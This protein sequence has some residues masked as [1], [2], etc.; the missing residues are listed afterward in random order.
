[1]SC[2][3]SS[4]TWRPYGIWP[5]RKHVT[6]TDLRLEGALSVSWFSCASYHHPLK[7]ILGATEPLKL[8]V[9][10]RLVV[11]SQ[12]CLPARICYLWPQMIFTINYR[13]NGWGSFG[14]LL[15]SK[16]KKRIWEYCSSDLRQARVLNIWIPA[17]LLWGKWASGAWWEQRGGLPKSRAYLEELE[18]L[19]QSVNTLGQTAERMPGFMYQIQWRH[20]RGRL[21]K[22]PSHSLLLIQHPWQGL[23]PTGSQSSHCRKMEE[24]TGD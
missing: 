6:T 22:G 5:Q 18:L 20:F 2:E 24:L 23:A 17:K 3:F 7:L 11:L 8:R 4:V 16:E 15:F 14:E 19:K 13:N 12:W 10:F 9:Q 1:M 21:L